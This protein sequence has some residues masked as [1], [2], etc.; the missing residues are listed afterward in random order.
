MCWH[1]LNGFISELVWPPFCTVTRGH[2]TACKFLCLTHNEA[3]KPEKSRVWSREMFVEEPFKE[4]RVTCRQKSLNWDLF[5]PFIINPFSL[6]LLILE[7]IRCLAR[8]EIMFWVK[9]L[10][11]TWQKNSILRGLG[12]FIQYYIILPQIFKRMG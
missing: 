2:V 9:R 10:M 8:R 6:T 1:G 12:F 11:L 7:E 3:K 4:S 5:L